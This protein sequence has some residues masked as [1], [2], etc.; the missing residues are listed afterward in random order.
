MTDT[1]KGKLAAGIMTGIIVCT[2][3]VAAC[4][5]AGKERKA[6][7]VCRPMALVAKFTDGARMVSVCAAANGGYKLKDDQGP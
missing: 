1:T 6:E 7:A 5:E 4:E 2:V 3:L